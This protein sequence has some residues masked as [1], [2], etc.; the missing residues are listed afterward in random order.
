MSLNISVSA[1]STT[2][3][4]SI[5]S[6]P[7]KTYPKRRPSWFRGYVRNLKG[8]EYELVHSSPDGTLFVIAAQNRKSP[9]ETQELAYY[10]VAEGKIFQCPRVQTLL[11]IKMNE[12]AFGIDSLFDLLFDEYPETYQKEVE[13]KY[14]LGLSIPNK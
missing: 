3:T 10:C 1:N 11:K 4:A 9:T 7:P 13:D 5:N 6:Q 8:L 14:D 2:N 12:I